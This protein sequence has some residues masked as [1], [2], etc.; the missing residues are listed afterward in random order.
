MKY[1]IEKTTEAIIYLKN[2]RRKYGLV[3]EEIPSTGNF[4]FISNDKIMY[5]NETNGQDRVEIIPGFMIEAI[6]TDLR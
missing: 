6:E 1:S 4:H 2:G 3:S 5:F